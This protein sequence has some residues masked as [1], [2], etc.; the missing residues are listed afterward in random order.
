[1]ELE[2]KAVDEL[3]VPPIRVD[4]PTPRRAAAAA[5]AAPIGKPGKLAAT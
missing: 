3:F 1:M 4:P 5:S 2:L